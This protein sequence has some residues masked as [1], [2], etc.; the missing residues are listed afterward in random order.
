MAT[1]GDLS[2][3]D[4][5]RLPNNHG[6]TSFVEM[7]AEIHDRIFYFVHVA[8]RSTNDNPLYKTLR[9]VS[10]AFNGIATPRLFHTVVLYQHPDRWGALNN[11]AQ[12]PDL[13][14]HVKKLQLAHI[15]RLPVYQKET[16]ISETSHIRGHRGEMVEH[17]PL[18]GAL[19]DLDFADV[20]AGFARYSHWIE[21]E[22]LMKQHYASGTAL[23]LLLD[24]FGPLEVETI[25]D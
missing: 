25:G 16:W 19:A 23:P 12:R 13:S 6:M 14:I 8:G 5:E 18:G 9:Q 20:D 1:Q 22:Q 11:I 15:P 2:I 10:K 17:P 7:P 24:S 4:V 3:Q 21:G